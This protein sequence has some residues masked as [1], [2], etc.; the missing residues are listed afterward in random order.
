[1]AL[2]RSVQTVMYKRHLAS[3]TYTDLQT[4][5][6]YSKPLLTSIKQLFKPYV[7]NAGIHGMLCTI[8]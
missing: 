6:K 1:M 3:Y 5:R 8:R 4:M 7:I 2:R